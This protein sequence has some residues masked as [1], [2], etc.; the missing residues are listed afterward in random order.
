MYSAIDD[1][2]TNPIAFTRKSFKQRVDRL[3]VAVHHVEDTGRQPSFEEQ[4]GDAHRD[5]RIAL[6]WLQDEGIAAGNRWRSFPERDHGREIERRDAGDDAQRLAH[7][8]EVDPRPS[9]FGVLALEQLR[10]AAGELNHLD[11]ALDVALGVSQYLAVFGGEELREAVVLLRDQLEELEH[12]ACAALWIGRRPGGLRGLR[13]R[14]DLLDFGLAG[15]RDLGLHLAGVRIEDVAASAGR[16]LDLFSADEMSDFAHENAPDHGLVF[17][18]GASV[19]D[20]AA[21]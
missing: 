17:F 1:E 14:D 19:C 13:V 18:R 4:L 6:G 11:A 7:G 12:H 16:P 21:G 5:R 3:L 10:N 15:E 20:S 9:A 2:P 8:V